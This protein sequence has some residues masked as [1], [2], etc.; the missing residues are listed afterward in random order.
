MTESTNFI[1]VIIIRVIRFF[2]HSE[3]VRDTNPRLSTI[4]V[5]NPR[6][7]TCHRPHTIERIERVDFRHNIHRGRIIYQAHQITAQNRAI[8]SQAEQALIDAI[9][10]ARQEI[11]D[12]HIVHS[13]R[14]RNERPARIAPVAT[15][16]RAVQNQDV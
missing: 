4:V 6:Q 13:S 15:A 11:K 16:V 14:I 9:L 3:T 1:V 7:R 8:A 12:R 10:Q 2:F 5:R